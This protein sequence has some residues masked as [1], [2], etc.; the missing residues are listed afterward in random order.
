MTQI[1]ACLHP[2]TRRAGR[3]NFTRLPAGV[4]FG[5]LALLL[6]GLL[7]CAGG[8][9]SEP[10][11]LRFAEQVLGTA[12]E[13]LA[14]N[15]HALLEY[16]NTDNDLPAAPADTR[17]TPGGAA[18]DGGQR[19]RRPP[20]FCRLAPRQPGEIE[21]RGLGLHFPGYLLGVEKTSRQTLGLLGGPFGACSDSDSED[22]FRQAFLRVPL[23]TGGGF[24][25]PTCLL[26]RRLDDRRRMFLSHV[27]AFRALNAN[28][29]TRI[30]GAV[31]YD[32]YARN[33]LLCTIQQA[34][35]TGQPPAWEKGAFFAG[36]AQGLAELENALRADL[37]SAQQSGKP[38]SH[39]FVYVM[40]WNTGEAAS[41][42]NFNALFG[43]LLDAAAVDAS[44]GSHFR[45][46]F[47]GLTWP[48]TWSFGTS[49]WDQFV[50]G[51]SFW[52]KKNDADELGTT[53]ANYLVN[54]V[55][56][57]IKQEHERLRVVL[58][59]HSFGARAV[60]RALYSCPWLAT[61]GDCQNTV[62]LVVGLQSAFGR[63]RFRHGLSPAWQEAIAVHPMHHEGIPYTD[64][65]Q[66][67]AYRAKQAYLWSRY[68]SATSLSAMIGGNN[69]VERTR[70]PGNQDL[71]QHLDDPAAGDDRSPLPP[72]SEVISRVRQLAAHDRRVLLIDGAGF[73]RYDTPYHG[74]D[75][76]SD[77]Y[78][79][80]TGQLTWELVKKYA[81]SAPPS[82]RAK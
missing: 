40:G 51:V 80:E 39:V 68:D 37:L 78:T 11:H 73:V 44:A 49:A 7:G 38:Y 74:G 9:V 63:S 33:D 29:T 62:D 18:P 14:W 24:D 70:A 57:R 42:E 55:L 35:A 52:N 13:E 17:P 10:K 6:G 75:A 72:S 36:R 23:R 20:D 4:P 81:P 48:S 79:R 67:A 58:V 69:E 65:S 32:V 61:P 21:V 15:F 64:Y 3:P 16:K 34:A 2:P 5:L 54:E 46:L 66:F 30:G 19:A 82:S 31:L 28:A 26:K 60:S 77:I 12:E 41:I 76:H 47:I 8:P 71:F 50:R 45:P 1:P 43:Y 56:T 22:I 27:V 53:W 25:D 59:G